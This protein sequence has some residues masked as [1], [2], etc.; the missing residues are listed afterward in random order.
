VAQREG[1]EDTALPVDVQ[2]EERLGLHAPEW[3]DCPLLK[4]SRR[5]AGVTGG[6]RFMGGPMSCRRMEYDIVVEFDPVTRRFAA[7]VAGLPVFV[8]GRTEEEAI[9]LAREGI[10]FYLEEGGK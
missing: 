8:D 2:G 3:D 1:I 7:N 6:D 9:R 10:D 4:L 5:W